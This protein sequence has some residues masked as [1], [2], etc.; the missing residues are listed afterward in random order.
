MP[1]AP[2]EDPVTR[3][4][5]STQLLEGLR[6][7]KNDTVWRHFVERYRPMLV[8]YAMNAFHFDT[9]DAEDAAQVALAAFAKAYRRG[10]YDREKGRLRNWLFGIATNRL[11]DLARKKARVREVQVGSQTDGAGL[12][13]S[14]AAED[15]LELMWEEEWRRA[16]Y[17]HCMEEVRFQF[18]PKTVRAFEMY[19]QNG[20]AAGQVA[21]KLGMTA[22]AVYLARHHVLKRIREMLPRIENIW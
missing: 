14:I 21:E 8:G 13:P 9:T 10:Q 17:G 20:L 15:Q 18:D 19:T 7:P 16:V 4:T 1:T 5:T 6:D 12:I 2:Y 11:N 3:T 22:N